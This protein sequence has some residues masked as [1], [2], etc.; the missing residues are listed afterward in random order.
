MNTLTMHFGEVEA[1]A[2]TGV[3][4]RDITTELRRLISRSGIING[5]LTATA[6]GSTASVTA[7]E[8]EPGAVADLKRRINAL[9]PPDLAYEHEKAWHDGN[10]HSHVQAALVGPSLSAP[11]RNGRLALGTWQQ[12]VVV[13]HDNRPRKRT[14]AVSIIGYAEAE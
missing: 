4:I 7:I 2:E 11:I 6:I 9:A 8:F 3:D 5:S 13:N 1:S 12:V 14:V 10:G